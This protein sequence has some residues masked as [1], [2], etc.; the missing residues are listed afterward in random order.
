MED[1]RC[2][3]LS[4]DTSKKPLRAETLWLGDRE[5]VLHPDR[6]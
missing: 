3:Q 5:Y 2:R 1:G 6:D 4:A